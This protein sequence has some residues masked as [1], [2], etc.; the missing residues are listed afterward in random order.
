M[1]NRLHGFNE[2]GDSRVS[3]ELN[4][5]SSSILFDINKL[6]VG[7]ERSEVEVE[8][9]ERSEGRSMGESRVKTTYKHLSEFALLSAA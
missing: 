6:G 9:S 3:F 7:G 5:D 1:C 8:L 4:I 2:R